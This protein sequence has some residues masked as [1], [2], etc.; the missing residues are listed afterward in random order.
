VSVTFV[1]CPNPN[2]KIVVHIY[3]MHLSLPPFSPLCSPQT[4]N[5]LQV[6]PH[7]I[8][9]I[10]AMKLCG[11]GRADGGID[12]T[13]GPIGRGRAVGGRLVGGG[14]WR[15][16]GSVRGVGVRSVD[17]SVVPMG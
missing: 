7:E 4:M 6:A 13:I 12:S 1:N 11:D 10:D 5:G 14:L 3:Q 17:V 8:V 15:S 2:L 9:Y 16:G